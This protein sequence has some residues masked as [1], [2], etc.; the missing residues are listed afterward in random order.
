MSPILQS[1]DAVAH[2]SPCVLI[3]PSSPS[4]GP[5]AVAG[6]EVALTANW[7]EFY[8]RSIECKTCNNVRALAIGPCCWN[9]GLMKMVLLSVCDDWDENGTRWE[10]KRNLLLIHLQHRKVDPEH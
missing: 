10:I 5:E 3:H 2:L 1:A 8:T 9:E 7:S 6:C 4:F